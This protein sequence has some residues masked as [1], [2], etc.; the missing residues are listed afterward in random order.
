[1]AL[2]R[3]KS[4]AQHI[5]GNPPPHPFDPL[6]NAEIE[7]A[8][9]IVRKEKGQLAYNAVTLLEPRKNEMLPW[10]ANSNSKRPA[11]M[12]DVVAIAP[13]GKVVEGWVDLDEKKLLKWDTLDDVQPLV[14]TSTMEGEQMLIILDHN[15]GFTTGRTR[16]SQR[17][18]S[19]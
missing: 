16:L 4:V 19:H 15:G 11:R 5:I 10:L 18:Q 13:G 7:A 8:V 1:M 3:L 9:Q 6:T 12:A 17:P 2:D 14:S